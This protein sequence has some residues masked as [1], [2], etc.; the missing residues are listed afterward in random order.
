MTKEK[1]EKK[2]GK[3]NTRE[4]ETERRIHFRMKEREDISL[5]DT[6]TNNNTKKVSMI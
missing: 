1:T 4:D 6:L 2:D 5:K 3:M